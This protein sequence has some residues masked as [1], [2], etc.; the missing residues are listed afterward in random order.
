MRKKRFLAVVLTASMTM[1]SVVTAWAAPTVGTGSK[2]M[3]S[4]ITVT[5]DGTV[6][7]IVDT[8][9][10]NVVV[11]TTVSEGSIFDYIMDPQELIGETDAAKYVA[12]AGKLGSENTPVSINSGNFTKSSLYFV[13]DLTV[14]GSTRLSNT[15]DPYKLINKSVMDVDVSV[16]AKL[17]GAQ[18]V[19]VSTDKTFK[20]A[21]STSMYMAVKEGS[22]EKA[23]STADAAD[24][25]LTATMKNAKDKYEKKL[26]SDNSTYVYEI[27]SVNKAGQTISDS[28]FAGKYEFQ[29]TG[30]CNTE[31]DWSGFSGAN[32]SNLSAPSVVVTYYLTPHTPK[33]AA[34]EASS[35]E[36]T[37]GQDLAMKLSLGDMGA[38]KIT[39]ITYGDNK[40]LAESN[41][42]Y[43]N[44][45]LTF[46]SSYISDLYTYMTD[47]TSR[48]YT[49]SFDEGD[50]A[51][52][53]VTITR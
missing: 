4:A 3:D 48:E 10:F 18:G 53:T 17:S 36:A 22:T 46:K 45:T 15:S 20:D 39:S 49:V 14:S 2:P 27:P 32:L 42:T 37:N 35:Y 19:S 51:I 47:S 41:Y 34:F 29:L 25:L 8:N 11:P 30:A 40:T 50:P 21:E 52:V 33:G 23:I 5:G 28:D 13:N 43:S 7:G 24:Y 1:A 44:G 6:E 9:I 38:T 16:N 31:A 12:G 26:L